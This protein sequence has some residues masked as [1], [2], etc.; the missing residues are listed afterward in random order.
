MFLRTVVKFVF[1]MFQTIEST[2]QVCIYMFYV[3]SCQSR[4]DRCKS[5]EP[6][7]DGSL[8]GRNARSE[9]LFEGGMYEIRG[10]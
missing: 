9:I 8:L 10:R 7:E 6:L 3:S 4:V 5:K 1:S 2:V